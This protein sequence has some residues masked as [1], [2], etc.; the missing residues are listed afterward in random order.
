MQ[1]MIFDSTGR[2]FKDYSTKELI[3]RSEQ[4]EWA[5]KLWDVLAE[6][7]ILLVGIPEELDDAGGD[8]IDAFNILRLAGK[9]AAPLP[10]AETLM[11]SGYWLKREKN[12]R[13]NLLLFLF[14]RTV[15]LS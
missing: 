9:Y 4:G 13:Q 11:L 3:D 15:N 2:M 7:G 5:G 1:E 12:L 10:I 14:R 8:Y 6:S